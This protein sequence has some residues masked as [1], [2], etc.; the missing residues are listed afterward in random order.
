MK[1][2][3]QK[4]GQFGNPEQEQRLSLEAVTKGL[5]KTEDTRVWSVKCRHEL[6]F[7]V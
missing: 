4:W 7:K 3:K 6:W 1:E 5:V 2:W